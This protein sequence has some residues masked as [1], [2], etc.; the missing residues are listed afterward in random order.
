MLCSFIIACLVIV[1]YGAFV[2]RTCL[3]W[4]VIWIGFGCWLLTPGLV[5]CGNSLA[6][7]GLG[8]KLLFGVLILILADFWWLPVALIGCFECLW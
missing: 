5:C 3:F 6:F 4:F 7:L 1:G 8:G 2:L